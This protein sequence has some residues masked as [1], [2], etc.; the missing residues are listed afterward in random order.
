MHQVRREEQPQR[1][2]GNRRLPSENVDLLKW[3]EHC[4]TSIHGFSH[5]ATPPPIFPS[6]FPSTLSPFHI[7]SHPSIHDF[8]LFYFL[9]SF[10]LSSTSNYSFIHL[11]FFPSI[12][13]SIHT[14]FFLYSQSFFIHPDFHSIVILL[15]FHLTILPSFSLHSFDTFIQQSIHLSFILTSIYSSCHPPIIPSSQSFFLPYFYSIIHSLITYS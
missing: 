12:L 13:P 14:S 10:C 1:P 15:S 3:H 5:P 2:P 6:I 7:S 4:V 8:L 11:S 9:S